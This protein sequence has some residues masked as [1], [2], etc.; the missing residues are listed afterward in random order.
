MCISANPRLPLGRLSLGTAFSFE[1]KAA[2]C[3]IL[4]SMFSDGR[5]K[6]LLAQR[7]T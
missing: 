2:F 3:V 1:E 7:V 4:W 6:H 5:I